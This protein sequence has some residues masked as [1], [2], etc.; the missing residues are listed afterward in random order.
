MEKVTEDFICGGTEKRSTNFIKDKGKPFSI[1]K[2]LIDKKFLFNGC[3][4]EQ[5]EW[6]SIKMSMEGYISQ[7]YEIPLS[8]ERRKQ[9]TRKATDLEPTQFRSLAGTLLWLG[10]GVLSPAAYASSTMQQKLS[11]L[12]VTYLEEAN[13]MVRYI[14]KFKP[15]ILYNRPANVTRA[16]VPTFSDASF[17][18]NSRKSYLQTG[19]VLG[20]RTFTDDE[21]EYFHTLDWVS[22]KQG[23]ICHT[24]YGAEIMACAEGYERGYYLKMGIRALLPVSKIRN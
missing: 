20:I 17:N 8:R 16:I 12:K 24:S 22:T 6:G 14:K 7:L 13:E 3:E 2:A 9:Q 10:K 19:L 23:R 4:V 18:I 5:Y 1:V 15:Y 21:T 11:N